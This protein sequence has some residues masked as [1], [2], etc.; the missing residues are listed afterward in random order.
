MIV[1]HRA[2]AVGSGAIMA[3]DDNDGALVLFGG[4]ADSV[5]PL[6]DQWMLVGT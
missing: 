1:A 3:L 2:P 4:T 5:A 6:S